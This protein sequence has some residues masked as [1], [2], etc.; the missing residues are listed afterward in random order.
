MNEN[1]IEFLGKLKTDNNQYIIGVITEAYNIYANTTPTE[2]YKSVQ[3][4]MDMIT[5][6]SEKSKPTKKKKVKKLS[7]N[8]L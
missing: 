2:G 3:S 4:N 8:T 1:F 5:E 7:L 6:N